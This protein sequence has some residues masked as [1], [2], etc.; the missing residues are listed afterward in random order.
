MVYAII[1]IAKS[2]II[3]GLTQNET[4]TVAA[5]GV[6][7]SFTTRGDIARRNGAGCCSGQ[8]TDKG[9][10]ENPWIKGFRAGKAAQNPCVK[11]FQTMCKK[12][13]SKDP[14]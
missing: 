13:P 10:I 11:S 3:K 8:G 6:S 7:A 4:P 12:F 5:V 14:G 1:R 2:S 9:K